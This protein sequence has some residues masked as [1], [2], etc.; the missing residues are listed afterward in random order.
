MQIDGAKTP[1]ERREKPEGTP[2]KNE[3]EPTMKNKALNLDSIR[4]VNYL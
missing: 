4:T 2:L 3:G 1:G